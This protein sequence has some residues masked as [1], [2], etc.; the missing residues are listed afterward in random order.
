ME[1]VLATAL[2]GSV[3]AFG[4]VHRAA[5]LSLWGAT[6]VLAALLVVRCIQVAALRRLVGRRLFSFHSSGLW[7]VF[8]D[9]NPY[10]VAGWSYDL[11]KPLLAFGPASLPGALFLGWV[12]L[13]LVALPPDL[14]ALLSSAH[15]EVLAEGSAWLPLSLTPE[16]TRHG[17]AFLISVLALHVI[18]ASLFQSPRAGR[19]FRTF[20]ALLGATLSLAALVQL[21]S[22]VR[23]IYG[24]YT[25]RWTDGG[26]AFFG[27][28][29]NRNHFAAYMLM[30]TPLSLGLLASRFRLYRGAV[31]RRANLRRWLVGLQS[32]EGVATLYASVPALACVAALVAARSRG[33]LLAFGASL[34][35]AG[36]WTRRRLAWGLPLALFA[37]ATLW[38]GLDRLGERFGRVSIEAS[39]R[40]IVWDN[41]LSRMDGLWLTGSGFNTFASAMSRVTLWKLPQGATPW[42]E[43][44]E[45]SLAQAPRMGYLS[46]LG[47]P[48][49]DWYR[50]AHNDYLQVLVE[51]GVP[52]LLLILATAAAIVRRAH[53]NPWLLAAVSGV[54]LHS[55]VDFPLQLPAVSAMF[56]VVA[57]GLDDDRGR[58]AARPPG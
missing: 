22:G 47:I 44:Y 4:S 13:Q 6:S 34:A 28:F 58:G 29:V 17:V 16:K 11:R 55:I 1:F 25:P 45:T 35:V 5:Y 41:T 30:L 10:G 21:A 3:L 12:L 38:F 49:L 19:R 20:A 53:R 24:F 18:A 8:G 36:L 43:P 48:R 14:V 46:H 7:I 9:D 57:A 27:P 52:G 39:G 32:H 31:G 2:A 42:R 56:A 15:D 26:F 40:T 50:E 54:L 23:A 51:T 33:G 37:T